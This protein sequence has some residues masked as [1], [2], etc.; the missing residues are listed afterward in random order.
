MFLSCRGGGEL[1]LEK[2]EKKGDPSQRKGTGRGDRKKKRSRGEGPLSGKKRGL[3]LKR[4]RGILWG[5]GKILWGTLAFQGELPSH[6]GTAAHEAL[7]IGQKY[8]GPTI[9]PYRR[10]VTWA[11]KKG[12][13]RERRGHLRGASR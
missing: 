10:K 2:A 4:N 9:S 13:G 8:G 12:E 7:S 6:Q 1:Y 5:E 3:A 11:A